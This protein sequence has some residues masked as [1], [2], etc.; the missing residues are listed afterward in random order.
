MIIP[1]KKCNPITWVAL[2]HVHVCASN[3]ARIINSQF[4]LSVLLYEV[5]LPHSNQSHSI[6]TRCVT[7]HR[8]SSSNIKMVRGL[9]I[10]SSTHILHSFSIY[11]PWK[12][13]KERSYI[14]EY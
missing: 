5:W 1:S 4:Q 12:I 14:R 6:V 2:C 11:H 9:G 10:C 8:I 3:K 7:L 13:G